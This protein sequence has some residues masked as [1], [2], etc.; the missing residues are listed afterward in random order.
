MLIRIIGD[1]FVDPEHARVVLITD[2]GN[3]QLRRVWI[4]VPGTDKAIEVEQKF[5]LDLFRAKQ[6]DPL[7]L[8]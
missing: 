5:Q 3:E 4:T 2:G 8:S 6:L 1:T 7:E